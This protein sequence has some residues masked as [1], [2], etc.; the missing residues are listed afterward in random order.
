MTHDANC[1]FGAQCRRLAREFFMLASTRLRSR[2]AYIAAPVHSLSLPTENRRKAMQHTDRGILS[3]SLSWCVPTYVRLDMHHSD[4][5]MFCLPGELD[6]RGTEGTCS[7]SPVSS[8]HVCMKSRR[9]CG[10]HSNFS[11]ARGALCSK[12]G[13]L[14]HNNSPN[15]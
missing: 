4:T 10:P 12:C 9:G 6:A 14:S 15:A 3:F 5:F 8:R 7:E 13:A 1:I 11:A 2:C